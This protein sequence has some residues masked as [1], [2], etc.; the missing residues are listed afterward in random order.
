MKTIIEG[1]APIGEF[2]EEWKPLSDPSPDLKIKKNGK[3]FDSV[4]VFTNQPQKYITKIGSLLQKEWWPEL[5]P[6]EETQPPPIGIEPEYI[7]KEKRI[8]DLIH[9][10]SR[11]DKA[12]LPIPKNWLKELKSHLN[13]TI[14]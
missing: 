14:K 3:Y 9:A 12:L 8:I 11:Y 5:S 4:G 2:P 10:I 6:K 7:W 1:Y 13:E